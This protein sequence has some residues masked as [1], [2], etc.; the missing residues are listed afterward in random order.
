MNRGR[1]PTPNALALSI[2]V[3]LLFAQHAHAQALASHGDWGDVGLLQTPSARMDEEG[4]FA[5]T[6]SHTSPYS[7]YTISLQPLPWL[8]GE[9]RYVNVQGVPY[10]PESLSGNQN[11]KDKS[12]DVKLRLWQES[13]W[14]PQIALGVRDLGGTGLFSGEYLVANKRFGAFDA[15]LG[16]ATGYMGHRGD[17]ANPLGAIDDR[18]KTRPIPTSNIANAGKF[19]VSSMFRG[20]VGAFGGVNWQTPW[21]PLSI[22]LEY[23][24]NDYEHEPKGLKI[25]QRS[26]VN[27]GAVFAAS[28]NIQFTV[29]WERGN[30]AVFGLTLHTNVGHARPTPKPLDPPPV[31]LHA[32]ETAPS[33]PAPSLSGTDWT[34]LADQLRKNAGFAVKTIA[35]R[36]GNEIVVTGSQNR[37]T[38][39]AEGLGRS[40]RLLDNTMPANVEW[41]TLANE[42]G[43]LPL[44]QASVQRSAVEDYLDHRTDTEDLARHIEFTPTLPHQDNV[45]YRAPLKRFY[46]GYNLGYNQILGGPDAFILYQVSANYSADFFFSDHL[47]LSGT[48]SYD[49]LN[50]YD[51]FRYD[52]PSHLPRVR[53]DLRQYATTSDFTLPNLQLTSTWQYSRDVFGMA[54]GGLLESM[55]GGVGSE[56]LY[57]PFGENWAMGMDANWVK[58][59]G[60]RQNFAF[61][62]YDVVTGHASLYYRFGDQHPVL[63][64]L[65]AG[66]YLA[67]DVGATLN[68]A[69]TF[70]NGVSMGAWAT[71]TNVSA[72]EFGEGSFDKGIYVSVPL[73]LM[74]PRSSR[75]RAA[76]VWDPLTRDGGARLNRR[77]NLYD[78]TDDRESGYLFDNLD[79]FDR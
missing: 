25:D 44:S 23:D 5:I 63:A 18:F 14:L 30:Q 75:G 33:A 8:E 28:K 71:K 45:L 11:Y 4:E 66:R 38:Y 61:R 19:G 9:F 32:R 31:A 62:D 51:K 26:P 68:L 48:A 65:S 50:N 21:E 46:G 79:M 58:Q 78:L 41:F 15:S 6:A 10:G 7:R 37:Y 36:D 47:W 3:G 73:D 13:H 54:Y 64:T 55:F 56:V 35:E 34:A 39:P 72:A 12:V 43:G 16:L 76:M 70:R 74:L 57:R 20:R 69:R 29:G 1:L 77:Y 60:F 42:R 17:F 22:K 53:T 49:L 2:G 27:L 52:A 59:R 67:G 24:G 40:G